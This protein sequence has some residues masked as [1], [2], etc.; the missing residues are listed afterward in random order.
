MKDMKEQ[1]PRGSISPWRVLIKALLLLVLVNFAFILVKDVPIGKLSLYNSV[2][3]GRQR[4]PFGEN[5]SK[6]Y[7]LSLYNLDAM[8]ASHEINAAQKAEEEFRVIVV[9]DSSVWGFMQEPEDTLAG[10]LSQKALI[11]GKKNVHVF[12]LGYPSLSIL[13]DLMIIDRVEAYDPD[14]IVWMVTLESLPLSKQL[15]TP[16]VENNPVIV[17]R[18]IDKYGLEGLNKTPVD[19]LDQ[20][21]IARRRELADMLRLQFY[22]VMWSATGIDQEYP[23]D[24]NPA[25]RDFEADDIGF[26]DFEIGNLD[27]NQLVIDVITKTIAY[28][29]DIDFV[30]INEPI[31]ISAGENS[32]IRYDYYYPRWAYDQYRPLMQTEMEAYGI[33]YYDLWDIVPEA[34]FTNSAIHLSSKGENILADS[35]LP[36]IV[37]GCQ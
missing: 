16:L 5:P 21:L 6:S 9:G 20:T 1:K 4:L 11:C 29:T 23:Q 13:K 10:M 2:L 35:V 22:G 12:N 17:N 28:H 19:A 15:E 30:V 37:E 31:L 14:M 8:L 27:Q 3:K 24:Y 36:I 18:L 7:N 33:N 26:Y 25:L 34:E 32:D